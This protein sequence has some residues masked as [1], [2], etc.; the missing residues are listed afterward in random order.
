MDVLTIFLAIVCTLIVAAGVTLL[1]DVLA[2]FCFRPLDT[3]QSLEK[4]ASRS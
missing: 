2:S 4:Q 1:L 3:T